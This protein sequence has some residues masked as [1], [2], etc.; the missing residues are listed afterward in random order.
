MKTGSSTGQ[1]PIRVAIVGGGCAAMATA[2]ELTQ[3]AQGKRFEVTVYQLGWRLGGKG[4]SGRGAC[5]RVEEHGLH[6]W[7][8]HYDNAFR[9]MRE[10][11]A[12]LSRSPDHPL[13]T[14]R[15]AF[16]PDPYVGLTHPAKGGDW[17][18]LM[19][20]FPAM[21]GS[22]GDPRDTGALTSVTDYLQ[23][24]VQLLIELVQSARAV[25]DLATAHNGHTTGEPSGTPAAP[26]HRLS[27]EALRTS[28]G[29]VLGLGQVATF[30]VLKHALGLLGIAIGKLPL[31][32]DD[33][34]D[35]L[36]NRI[37]GFI[38]SLLRPHIERST[39]VR[40]VWE[41]VDIVLAQLRGSI[42]FGLASD[43][44]GFEV[45][46]DYDIREWLRINGASEAALESA[47]VR[48]LYD[49]AFA[50]EDG[51][52]DRAG[53]AAGQGLRGGLR[54]FFQYREAL[55]WKMQGGMGDV[56]FAPLYEALKARGVKF[57]F[58][59]KLVNT[60]MAG[61]RG[62]G[63]KGTGDTP[64]VASLTFDVQASMRTGTYNPLV[65][66]DGVDC[67]PAE[68]VW[69]QLRDGE[70]LQARGTDFESFW[71][72]TR[73]GRKRLECGRD[74]D[75]VVI[76][77]SVAAL[78]Y[79]CEE[80]LARDARW[81]RMVEEVKTVPTQ[82]LQLWLKP[83]L[84]ALGWNES[85]PNLSAFVDPFDTW[86]DMSHLVA[87]ENWPVR[88]ES[89][90]R[91]I[92]YFCNVLPCPPLE[93]DDLADG[94]YPRRWLAQVK[95]NAIEFLDRDVKVLWPRAADANGFHWHLLANGTDLPD[96][97]DERRIET[98][99]FRANVN[100]TDR[101][102]LALPGSLQHRISPLDRT[103]DN[104]TIAGDWTDCG[105]NVGCVEAAVMSGRLAAHALSLYPPL[106]T[107]DG[108]DHP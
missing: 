76:G 46:D 16:K 108:Y 78:P 92:A 23:R 75:F 55:F 98:Q 96:Q 8:G 97:T 70:L 12:E 99:Y 25:D 11:Y 4:A 71:E 79:A 100:P 102:V 62:T 32:P 28:I 38:D 81:Q 6:L 95:S 36:I 85:P 5:G 60:G 33:L 18:R 30:T 83:D 103:Y 58:F 31:V 89:T 94:D 74:F 15:D 48:G 14:W 77:I 66:Y 107:I 53:I 24:T 73:V 67:W 2:W 20:R 39:S 65:N 52:S 45:I 88:P 19:A 105:F 61:G 63:D 72:H 104:L 27:I 3:P 91:T 37:S 93:E 69:S 1:Q 87:V 35:Q 50:Y 41:I 34:V 26:A 44:R 101:Y 56:V 47:F 84:K 51:V 42:R 10:C 49:L 80:I 29:E 9:L 106:E 68:P 90:P 86:A 64:H 7:M 40:Y 21:P 57:E 54:M 59:H 43:P 13:A 22:P 82:A 17:Q